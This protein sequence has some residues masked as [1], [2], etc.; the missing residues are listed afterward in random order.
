MKKFFPLLNQRLEKQSAELE[1]TR[2]AQVKQDKELTAVQQTLAQN[3]EG[4]DTQLRELREDVSTF[5]TR[6]DERSEAVQ[7]DLARLRTEL[8]GL[9]DE[10]LPSF[11][12]ELSSLLASKFEFI[13]NTL[14][15]RQ[16]VQH[17]E[18]AEREEQ[19]RAASKKNLR[20]VIGLIGLSIAA[21]ILFHLMQT[22]GVGK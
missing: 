21:Q 18:L 19:D 8:S 20:L 10:H 3:R 15:E 1:L 4:Q 9:Q 14:H 13:E 7:G 12:R 17:E 5:Q 22:P 2:K 16:G 11:R 6:A